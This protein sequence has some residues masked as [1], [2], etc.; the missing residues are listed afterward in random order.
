M[1]QFLLVAENDFV[2]DPDEAARSLTADAEAVLTEA[3]TALAAVSD[4][5]SEQ[6]ESALRVALV[7]GLGLKPR[8]AFGPVRVAVSGRRVSPPLFESME[9]L[10]RD[11]SMSRLSAALTETR[12]P[13]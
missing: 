4:W 2:V 5:D 13:G 8:V 12:S 6:I 7:E 11:R 1:L 9:I 3:Q 10:G